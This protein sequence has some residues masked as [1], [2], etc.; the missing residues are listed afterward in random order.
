MAI[1]LEQKRYFEE[2]YRSGVHGWPTEEPTR[3][4]KEFLQTYRKKK[5]RGRILDIGCGEGRHT[6]LFAGAGYR[7]IGVD[8]QH[9]AIN[10]AREFARLK[11]VTRGFQFV[12]GDVFSLPFQAGD[13][14][15]LIDY[16]CLH[17]VMKKDFKKYLASTLPL[18]KRGG[19]FLLS[20]F[21]SKFKHHPKERR[22][23]DWMVH[24]GHYDR[25]FRRTDFKTLFGEFYDILKTREERD[26]IHPHYVFHH[27]LMQKK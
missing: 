15:V 7:A 17:H 10:R 4:V 16:G 8:M 22:K 12:I 5:P 9:L 21:S 3:F 6:L 26:R 24:R 19:Y 25:F 11:G 1:Y 23:R 20:C 13:F 18:L 27:V 14:D 2:A